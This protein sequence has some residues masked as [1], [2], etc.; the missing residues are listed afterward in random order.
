MN[1]STWRGSDFTIIANQL[2]ESKGGESFNLAVIFD[3]KLDWV[4]SFEDISLS[5]VENK[6]QLKSKIAVFVLDE[7]EKIKE[8]SDEEY[9]GDSFSEVL[10]NKLW[11][12][13]KEISEDRSQQLDQK[14]NIPTFSDRVYSI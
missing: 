2:N 8:L 3:E 1:D 9:S 7:G 14:S 5:D 13:I 4:C 10:G 12:V 11:Q 6:I